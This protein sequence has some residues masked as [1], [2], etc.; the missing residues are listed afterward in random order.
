VERETRRHSGKNLERD[1]TVENHLFG[2]LEVSGESL[3]TIRVV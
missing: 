3:F 1:F 2:K